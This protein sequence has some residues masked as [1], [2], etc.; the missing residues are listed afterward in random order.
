MSASV[1][2]WVGLLLV[3]GLAGAC[4]SSPP[5]E[6]DFAE[7]PSAGDL[8]REGVAHLEEKRRFFFFRTRDYTEA[9]E[10]FQDVIDNYPYSDY[11]VLAE[12]K[13]ADAYYEQDRYEEA[14]SYY[15]D[16]ADL[17]PDHEQVPYTIYRSALCFVEQSHG[18]NRDQ[19][20]TEEALVQLERLIDRYPHSTHTQEA[21]EIWRELRERL[22]RHSMGIGDFYMDR[23]EYQSAADRY[24]SVLNEYPGLGLDAQALYKLGLCYTRMRLDDEAA[25]IFQVLLDDYEGT[26]VAREAADLVPAAH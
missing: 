12:L 26:D 22:A 13:I 7:V 17:H 16:F 6:M 18:P 19:T 21:E 2:G 23:E 4:A 10:A 1:S 5:V 24:R 8:Y 3:L 20:A 25:R 14:L 15:R 11:G 9:I